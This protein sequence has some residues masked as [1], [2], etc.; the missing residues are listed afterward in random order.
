M[1]IEAKFSIT[2]D[3]LA[4]QLRTVETLDGWTLT[5]GVTTRVRDVYLDTPDRRLLAAGYACRQRRIGRQRAYFITLKRIAATSNAIH[6]R[7]EYELTLDNDTPPAAWQPSP[8]RD[9]I[10]QLVGDAPLEKLFELRQTRF[11]REV[12]QGDTRLAAWSVDTV[13]VRAGKRRLDFAELEIELAPSRAPD[14]LTPLVARVQA[15][16]NLTPVTQSKFERALAWRDH[17]VRARQPRTPKIRLDDTMA[18]AARKTLLL[19]WNRML[20]HEAGVRAGVDIEETH[21]MRVATR[22]MRAAYRVFEEFLDRKTFKPFIKMLRRTARALGTVRD[23]EVFREKTERYLQTLPDAR[24]EE[25][26]PLLTVWQAEYQR[27]REA[28]L[29]W[30]DDD[31]YARFK[32]EFGEFLQTPGAGAAQLDEDVPHAPRVREVLP[33]ILLRTWANVYAYADIVNQPNVSLEQ[34]HQLRIASKGLRYTLEFFVDVLGEEAHPLIEQIKQLQDH[35]GN[36]QDA[37]VA[38]NHLRDFLTWGEWTH[39]TDKSARAPRTLVVA[40]GVATYL[41]VRQ[42]E[43]HTLVQTFPKVWTPI[44][45]ATFKRKLLALLAAW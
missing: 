13:S 29:A 28:L 15:L 41:A 11:T 21:D 9:L 19:H 31:T 42:S 33:V 2:D 12:M 24:K 6:T 30:L 17:L 23:L 44:Q 38:C 35:L 3:T 39:P 25:L 18:E 37:V 40:P 36:L 22:R 8:A 34:L 43:I 45:D 10:L 16:W 26:A 20:Q 4:E 14:D 32:T 7:D 1:E 5:R 27:A